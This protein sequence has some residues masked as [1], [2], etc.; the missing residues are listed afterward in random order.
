MSFCLNLFLKHCFF[1]GGNVYLLDAA[2]VK[3]VKVVEPLLFKKHVGN[4]QDRAALFRPP[5]DMLSE[6]LSPEPCQVGEGLLRSGQD[7]EIGPGWKL[8]PARGKAEMDQRFSGQGIE[9]VVVT[10]VGQAH[11]D[12]FQRVAGMVNVCRCCASN[13]L[14]LLARFSSCGMPRPW[15]GLTG[16]RRT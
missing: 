11:H 5:A 15:S 4:N 13:F 3:A 14:N 10:Q 16:C 2:F 9:F 12:D 8:R 7:D 6:P 1:C